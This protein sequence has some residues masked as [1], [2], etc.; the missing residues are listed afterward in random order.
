MKSEII[1]LKNK[2]LL[3]KNSGWIKSIR[4]DWGGIG[5][6]FEALLG[7]NK[8]DLEIPDYNGIELK[9]KRAYSNTNITL[10]NYAPEGPHYHEVERIK[11]LYGYPDSVL[12]HYNVLN[13]SVSSN[14]QSKV[15]LNY[16]FKLRVD[17]NKEKIFLL[18]Y[19]LN[20]NLI[21]D[22]VYWDFDTLREKVYRKLKYLAIA[23]ALVK[24]EYSKEYFKF[25]RLTIYKLKGFDDFINALSNGVIQISFKIGVFRDEKTREKFMIMEHPLV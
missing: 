12:K 22:S 24:S 10:F 3:I 18:V 16:Y 17:R 8:N 20:K 6:T 9:A 21:E 14:V 5:L 25:C 7:I 13:T 1:D 23:K 2:F 19:D 11:N 4:S 15:G